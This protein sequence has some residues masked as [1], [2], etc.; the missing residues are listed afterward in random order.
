MTRTQRVP[1]G[2]PG[3]PQPPGTAPAPPLPSE[4][5]RSVTNTGG[6]LSVCSPLMAWELWVLE[7]LAP[8]NLR[9]TVLPGPV[10]GGLLSPEVSC[11]QRGRRGPV[12]MAVQAEGREGRRGWGEAGGQEGR[13]QGEDG[14]GGEGVLQAERLPVEQPLVPSPSEEG[15]PSAGWTLGAW[16][17]LRLRGTLGLQSPHPGS[18]MLS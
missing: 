18:Q 6:P 8:R 13:A 10:W 16:W 12:W 11:L 4:W 9:S 2:E 1:S 3:C 5:P 15:G 17:T 14:A 7:T